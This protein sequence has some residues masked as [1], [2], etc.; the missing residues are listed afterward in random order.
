M[1]LFKKM[2]FF[3]IA[4]IIFV[5]I[6]LDGWYIY[7]HFF[8]E[9]K[10]IDQTVIVSDLKTTKLDEVTG[11]TIED[12]RVFAE[13]NLFDNVLEI[14]FNYFMSSTATD[15]YSQGV[16]LILKEGSPFKVKNIDAYTGS[17][18]TELTT[19]CV[20]KDKLSY[21]ETLY[22]IVKTKIYE[23]YYN[24]ILTEKIYDNFDLYEYQNYDDT[25]LVGEELKTGN[26][27]F[28][29]TLGN[30]VYG[31]K[32]KDYDTYFNSSGKEMIQ[33]DDLTKVGDNTYCWEHTNFNKVTH[34]YDY[35]TYYRALDLYYFIESMANSL[36]SLSESS[37]S[38]E[39]YVKMPDIFNFYTINSDGSMGKL[40]ITEDESV[41]LY[42]D[43]ANYFKIKV[44]INSGKMTS[45]TQS[46]F[47]AYAGSMDHNAEPEDNTMTEYQVGKVFIN[48]G[49]DDLDFISTDAF[50]VYDLKLSDNF[51]TYWNNYKNKCYVKIN[52]DLSELGITLG[53]IIEDKDFTIYE[54]TDSSKQIY[55]LSEVELC[56]E[57]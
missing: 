13:F 36:S 47:N 23:S 10:T 9:E 2:Q 44:K 24:V 21:N 4:V 28:K 8:G 50:G 7:L 54:I 49:I 51:K 6:G 39:T 43:F 22:F 42:S 34:Y 16:Q 45:S 19:E 41:K 15:F 18:N 20:E 56:L 12:K 35:T 1:N 48:A 55:R 25:V 14:K 17:Y 33:T 53:K 30:K 29:I 57:T 38:I 31:M 3:I 52:L 32:F 27:S 5:S 11:E 26:E 37:N 40:N 46:L